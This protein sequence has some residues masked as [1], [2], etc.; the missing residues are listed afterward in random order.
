MGATKWVR[1]EDTP[2]S[3]AKEPSGR[4]NPQAAPRPSG[5]RYHRYEKVH[6]A[7]QVEGGGGSPGIESGP[8]EISSGKPHNIAEQQLTGLLSNFETGS[9]QVL[10]IQHGR[11]GP[12]SSIRVQF[13]FDRSHRSPKFNLLINT[14][15][16][17]TTRGHGWCWGPIRISMGS[18]DGDHPA[19][20]PHLSKLPDDTLSCGLS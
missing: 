5:Y 19:V 12:M 1:E 17:K 11:W 18:W 10:T 14:E 15:P 16:R 2:H 20:Q 7:S 6:P 4:D 13:R 9:P 8:Q 3:G